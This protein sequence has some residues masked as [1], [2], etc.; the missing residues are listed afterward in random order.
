[1]ADTGAIQKTER[2]IAYWMERV[3]AERERALADFNVEAV[4][5]LRTAL[6][7]CRSMAESAQSVD[8]H[9][10]WKKMR[11]TGKIIF[12]A[13]GY[14]RDTQVLLEWVERFSSECPAVAD[15]LRAHLLQR[16]AELKK[17]AAAVVS[18]FSSR[19][20][21]RW[22]RQLDERL[23]RMRDEAP[24]FEV[25]A[26]ERYEAARALHARALRNRNK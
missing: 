26:L 1:M 15:R 24:V 12:S 19:R 10:A 6:R 22:T 2:G 21:L 5:D 17:T 23:Q 4:H 18:K 16:E 11:G 7:R 9:P 13:L 14:L 25:L 20:W 8:R 3:V